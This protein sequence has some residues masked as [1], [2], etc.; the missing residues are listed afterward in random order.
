L[1]WIHKRLAGALGFK[2]DIEEAKAALAEAIRLN[3]E[4]NSFARWRAHE[5]WITGS[6]YWALLEKTLNI[7]L[8]RAGFPE[9]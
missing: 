7:G 6:Q 2:G 5:P 3:P 8:R 1:H 4:I 9:D